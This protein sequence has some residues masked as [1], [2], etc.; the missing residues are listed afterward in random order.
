MPQQCIQDHQQQ[1]LGLYSLDSYQ[2]ILQH[3]LATPRSKVQTT[4][5]AR[6]LHE[7]QLKLPSTVTI[8]ET[9]RHWSIYFTYPATTMSLQV[10]LLY[11]AL[12]SP[13]QIA[14]NRLFSACFN[15]EQK[16]LEILKLM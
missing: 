8:T 13:V 3:I 2:L 11:S 7:K 14:L 1:D 12:G 10:L 5:N 4:L 15:P 16:S 6:I 9:R